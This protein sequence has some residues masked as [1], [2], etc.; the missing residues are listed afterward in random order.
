[1]TFT[2][3]RPLTKI[4]FYWSPALE[5]VAAYENAAVDPQYADSMRVASFSVREAEGT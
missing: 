5:I 1:M 4:K 3:I 2:G